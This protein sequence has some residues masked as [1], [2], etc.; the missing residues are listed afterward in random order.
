MWDLT[1]K[2]QSV[3]ERILNYEKKNLIQSLTSIIAI[4]KLLQNEFN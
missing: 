4:S 3:H 1:H 2:L